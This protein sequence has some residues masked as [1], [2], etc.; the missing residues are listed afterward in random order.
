MTDARSS[1]EAPSS[2]AARTGERAAWERFVDGYGTLLAALAR[3]M[4]ARRTG[5]GRRGGRGRGR[6]AKCSSR[7]CAAAGCCSAATTPRYRLSTYLGVICRTE[8]GQALA[9]RRGRHR[10]AVEGSEDHLPPR[11]GTLPLDALARRRARRGARSAAR[12]ARGT[13]PARPPAP[14]AALLGGP[15]LPRDRQ[16]PEPQPRQRRPTAP[17]REGAAGPP[18]ARAAPLGETPRALGGRS[19]SVRLPHPSS[20]GRPAGRPVGV[21]TPGAARLYPFANTPT[22]LP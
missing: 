10:A 19:G 14:H 13:R 5:R 1:A 7:C 17:P 16:G 3:R 18:R 2:A 12:G 21:P 6:L 20:G 11:A 15:R 4:L 22:P 9:R 8:V